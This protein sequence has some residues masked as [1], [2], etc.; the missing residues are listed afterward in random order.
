VRCKFKTRSFLGARRAT[1]TVT[2]SRPYYA[3]VQLEVKGYVR[4]DIV[5]HPPAIDFKN[6]KEGVGAQQRVAI[7]YAGNDSWK[8]TSAESAN[9]DVEVQLKETHRGEGLVGYELIANLKKNAKPGYLNTSHLMLKTNDP[10]LNEF[11]V[12]ITGKVEEIISISP[13]AIDV[14]GAQKGETISK[15][16][17]VKGPEPFQI[18]SVTPSDSRVEAKISDAKK[19]LHI[20]PVTL[21]VGKVSGPVKASLEIVTDLGGVKKKIDFTGIIRD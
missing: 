21:K 4:K 15:R 9:K 14:S 12:S 1:V 19:K 5:V 6:I 7:E 13:L 10:R 8:I 11:P 3:E 2:F 18:L 16:I 20:V 17:I